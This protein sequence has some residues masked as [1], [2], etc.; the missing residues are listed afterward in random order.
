MGYWRPLP[1]RSLLLACAVIAFAGA[2]TRTDALEPTRLLWRDPGDIGNADLFWG[3]GDPERAPK[4]PFAFLK[5]DASGTKPKIQVV[6]AHGMTW[7]V[8][9]DRRGGRGREVPA[10]IAAGRILWALG[11]LVEESY[12][13]RDGTIEGI[14]KLARGRRVLD[15]NGR[16]EQARFE[17][18]PPDVERLKIR[19]SVDDNPFV[20]SR[21]LSGLLIAAALVNN[22]DFRTGNNSV[23]RLTSG[24][25]QE[26]WYIVSDWGTAFGRMPPRRSRWSLKHYRSEAP[27]V[28][29]VDEATVELNLRPDGRPGG[30]RVPVQH[31]RWFSEL[32]TRLTEGQLQRAFVA[33]GGS[34]AEVQGFSARILEKLGELKEATREGS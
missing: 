9:F 33:A 2:G 29:R 12:L 11:Y 34:T 28:R 4:P 7:G 21:E 22:W 24:G 32:A 14:S 10:E 23:L 30:A 20:D 5:E 15:E 25:A 27:F 19:W 17:R 6:D 16:F 8:K 1:T 3:P 13:V 18:R 31:A 26:D